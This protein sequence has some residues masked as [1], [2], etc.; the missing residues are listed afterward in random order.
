MHRILSLFY[1]GRN[2]ILDKHTNQVKYI[3]INITEMSKT[4]L[5]QLM[6]EKGTSNNAFNT[7]FYEFT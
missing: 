5:V 1:K 7:S 2:I 3:K 6:L 4:N